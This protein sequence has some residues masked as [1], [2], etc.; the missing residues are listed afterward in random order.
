MRNRTKKIQSNLISALSLLIALIMLSPIIWG[1]FCSI[2][3]EGKQFHNVFSWF[4]PP[5]TLQNY[6]QVLMKTGVFRWF[7]NSL[8]VAIVT[9]ALS[10]LVSTLAA[11]SIAHISFKGSGFFYFYFLIG[12]LV[13]SEATIIPLFVLMSKLKLIDSYSGL[14][15]PSVAS[16]MNFVITYSFFR[17]LPRELFEA[18]RIDGGGEWIIYTKV[19][20]PLSRPIIATI[21]IMSFIAS[22]NNYIWPLLCVFSEKLYTLPIGIPTLIKI[23]RPDFVIPMCINM[24]ASLPMIILYLIFEKQIVQGIS[25]GGIKG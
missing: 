13:P 24:V 2:Q 25:T 7:C 16:S 8:I 11:Y 19:V 17:S 9:T 21:A 20:L 18:V 12:I 22:W 10:V 6:P 3:Y 5:Y 1:L 23:E 15:L 4:T 14:I